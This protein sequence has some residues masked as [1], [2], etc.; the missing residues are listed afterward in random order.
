[1]NASF[2]TG[3]DAIAHWRDDLRS[4][5]KPEV[6]NHQFQQP[7][8]IPGHVA[9]VG[10][11]PGAG[12]TAFITQVVVEGLRMNPDKRAL[13]ANC[14]MSPAAILDRQ[15]ARLSG[16]PAETIR[17]RRFTA[18]H[19]ERLDAGIATLESIAE[20]LAFLD[21]PFSLDNVAMTARAHSADIIV[22]DYVQRFSAPGKETESRAR[23]ARVMDDLRRFASLGLVV[24]ALSAVGRS[25]DER[26]R[27]SYGGAGLN[28]ASFRESSELEFGADDA[29]ILAPVAE[30]KPGTLV[31]KHL[32]CRHGPPTDLHLR[33]DRKHQDF[34]IRPARDVFDAEQ[35][36]ADNDYPTWDGP[37]TA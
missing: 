4:G 27:S 3:V 28:L 17:H 29:F 1:M 23:V 36:E 2:S 11:A 32:K 15:L 14:E 33:F 18:A 5:R 35:H 21:S 16:V 7:L 30:N 20:R 9:L 31:L 8:L 34:S 13:I 37:R 22:I 26:G 25:K 6:I 24:V 19:R 12:K 10:G